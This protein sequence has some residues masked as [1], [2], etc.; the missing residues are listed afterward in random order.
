MR[1]FFTVTRWIMWA[2]S[3]V[4]LTL[5]A[6]L[7]WKFP[8]VPPYTHSVNTLVFAAIVCFLAPFSANLAQL[9]KHRPPLSAR[10]SNVY[11]GI[12]WGVLVVTLAG[13]LFWIRL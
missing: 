4:M 11:T 2:V 3:L 13:V 12:F 8:L 1:L 7:V 10:Q 6:V 9:T 5:A